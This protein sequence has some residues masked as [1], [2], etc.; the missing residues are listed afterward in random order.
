MKKNKIIII[1][2]CCM[3]GMLLL[4]VY[5]FL[6]QQYNKK[7]QVIHNEKYATLYEKEY[8]DYYVENKSYPKNIDELFEY[9]QAQ[10]DHLLDKKV[11]F[12]NEIGEDPFSKGNN[13][14]YIPLYDRH[15]KQRISFILLSAGIDGD[16][17]NCI[18]D[19]D[20]L[21]MDTWWTSLKIYNYDEVVLESD[22]NQKYK[23]LVQLFNSSN[24]DHYL[25]QRP[26]VHPFNLLDYI[27]GKKDYVIQV[28]QIPDISF[29]S[30][31]NIMDD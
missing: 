5:F 14:H 25:P 13:I 9:R 11:F 24:I 12:M 20:T 1:S 29:D 6:K 3:S 4:S 30:D 22:Y 18:Q 17:D 2:I 7:M 16:W 19:T 8:T 15:S 27:S 26:I 23:N 31:G 28:G 10:F 21:Y